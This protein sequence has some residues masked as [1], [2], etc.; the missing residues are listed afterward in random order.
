MAEFSGRSMAIPDVRR[1]AP[2][3]GPRRQVCRP[4]L[5]VR[6]PTM[7]RPR[8]RSH[9]G[10]TT[11]VEAAFVLPVMILFV[12]GLIEIG[13]AYMVGNMLRAAC[14]RGARF[15]SAEGVTSAEVRTAMRSFL[16]S[17]MDS[18]KVTI[19]IKDGS[20]LNSGSTVPTTQ[21]QYQALPDLE[22]NNAAPRQL[23]IVRATVS[24]DAIAVVKLPEFGSINLA[25]QSISRHE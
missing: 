24:Y 7:I 17:A 4:T 6:E 22:L 25:G 10:G 8:R 19:L 20:S 15:G 1:R 21:S 5:A 11:A 3:P 16:S 23:F 13:H 18:S 12:F 14:L 9:R 2:S